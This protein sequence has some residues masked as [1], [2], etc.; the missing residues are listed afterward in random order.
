MTQR[1]SSFLK[2]QRN[3]AGAAADPL[4]SL[5]AQSIEL[6]QETI[7]ESDCVLHWDRLEEKTF[8]V[9]VGLIEGLREGGPKI[10]AARLYE[11]APGIF[12]AVPAGSAAIS[13]RLSLIVS[14]LANLLP[15]APEPPEI[16]N[17]S[18]ETPFC[19][20]AEE[21]RA[22]L[23]QKKIPV[24]TRGTDQ[25][26]SVASDARSEELQ[27]EPADRPNTP[28]ELLREYDC[29]QRPTE[30]EHA[31]EPA[32]TGSEVPQLPSSPPAAPHRLEEPEI[33]PLPAIQAE[34]KVSVLPT[35]LNPRAAMERLQELFLL[36]EDLD[37]PRVAE[38]ILKLPRIQGALV[39]RCGRGVLG[40]RLPEQYDPVV[41]LS[42][43]D[44][45]EQLARFT[46][47]LGGGNF[48]FATISA[49]QQITLV[50]HGAITLVV[51]HEGRFVPGV[52]QKLVETAKALADLYTFEP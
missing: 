22:R 3:S 30:K 2:R 21:E 36:E 24:P 48:S 27:Y 13:L 50:S 25:K 14:Q 9:P 45:I 29:A 7:G 32:G 5:A 28:L 51:I 17:Q 49:S 10:A 44:L 23:L 8:L 52:R 37:G 47:A 40:G 1:F 38:E 34:R 20:Q 6:C 43:P 46:A 35:A 15:E 31:R 12:D 41:A 11:I 39:I 26:H 4:T 18:F 42:A 19:R 16:V 33:E